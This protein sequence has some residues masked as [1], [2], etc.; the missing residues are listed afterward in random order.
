M[1]SI[2]TPQ[3]CAFADSQ[4]TQGIRGT[5]K[6]PFGKCLA[7][8]FLSRIISWKTNHCR[9]RLVDTSDASSTSETSETPE[10]PETPD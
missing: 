5:L 9:H 4:N 6:L 1:Y 8:V 2:T 3:I 7:E 10:T